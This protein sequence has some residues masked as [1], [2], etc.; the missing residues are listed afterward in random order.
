MTRI[1]LAD[2]A[3][4][5]VELERSFLK[6]TGCEIVT[7]TAGDEVLSSVRM[8]KPDLI[9]LSVRLPD[10]DGL[11]CCRQIKADPN[12]H[13]I[14]VVFVTSAVDQ[15]RC[16]EAGGDGFVSKPVT[17][18]RLLEAVRRFIPVAERVSERVAVAIKV[19]YARNGVD[20][21]GFTRDIG[22]SGIFLSTHETFERGD[23]VDLRFSLPGS[24][25]TV[26]QAQGRV[27]RTAKDEGTHHATGVGIQFT[28][29]SA[30]NHLE[31]SRFLRERVGGET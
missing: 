1:L 30:R 8:D 23:L 9:V 6:R 26:I 10:M 17:R 7:A 21:L 14:P 5:L 29:L 2:D 19:E 27:V 11:A 16:A 18:A 15:A 22:T 28:D 4:L 12:L 3:R 13:G 24:T 25:P 31:I 20:G